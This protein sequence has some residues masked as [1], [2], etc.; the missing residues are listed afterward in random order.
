MTK[1]LGLDLG[2]NSI[3]WAIRNT[4]LTDEVK[5]Q[6]EKFGVL[7][8]KK[9]V[10]SEKGIEYSFA[11]N[12][13]EKRL[14]RRLYQ[15]HKYR[16]WA[17]L[18][19][20]IQNDYCPLS[21]EG[22]NR[23]RKYDK[24]KAMKGEGGRAYPVDEKSFEAWIKLD[25]DGDGH[26][27]YSSPYQL[28][29][30]LAEKKMDLTIQT[31][32]FK[33]GRALY[34]IA[35]RRGF[36]SSR[37]DAIADETGEKQDAKSEIKKES[38][39]ETNL[40][41]KFGKSLSDFPTM[42]SALAFAE[43]QG[44]RVR[45]EWIQH[46]FRKHYKEECTK[47]FEFQ[48]LGTETE[49]YKKLIENSK[50]RYNG[51]IFYQRPL[52]S[53]KGLVGTCT[54]EKGKPRCPLS[55]PEFEEFRAL[56]LLNNIQYK[57]DGSWNNL[58]VDMR[59]QIYQKL[60]LRSSKPHFHF[61]EIR[62]FIEK[63]IG[64]KLNHRDDKAKGLEKSINYSDKTN[65]SACPTSARLKDIFGE[66]WKDYK[67]DTTI[68]RRNKKGIEHTISYTI[69]DIWHVLFSFNDEE[70]VVEFASEKLGLDENRTRK[71]LNA[72]KALQDGYGMLSLYAIKKINEFLREGF[73]YTEA[74][75]L[76]NIP[77]IIG[78]D[79]WSES[80]N[81]K[82]IK[83]SIAD[84]IEKN[85]QIKLIL[86]IVNNLTAKYK[87]LHNDEKYGFRDN[88]YIL[89]ETDKKDILSL[90]IETY[91]EKTWELKIEN[92]AEIINTITDLYQF[93]F[94]NG[95]ETKLFG[96]D[97][98]HVIDYKGQIYHKAVSHQFY[99]LPRIVDTIFD[100]I[101]GHFTHVTEEQL[102]KLYHPSMIE[103][104]PA[105]QRCDDG[106][107]YLQSPK[108]RAFKNPMA[109]RTLHELRKLINYLIKTNKIDEET[110][111]VVETARDL[112]DA[113]KRWAIETFQRQKQAE[114]NEYVEAIRSLLENNDSTSA[115]DPGNLGNVDKVRLWY[116]QSIDESINKG[117]GEYNQ[118]RWNNNSTALF[119]KLSQA[120]TMTE[121][122]RLWK[123]QNC[124]CLYTGRI[125]SITDLFDTNKIDFEHTIPRSISFDNSLANL[126]VC[127]AS[128]NRAVKKNQI[129]TQ[130][131]NF[132]NNS[133]IGGVTY[134]AIKPRL[135][136]WENKVAHIKSMIE[137]W[138]GK[139][140]TASTKDYKDDAIRQRHL[141]Q[142]ELDYW[143]N[144]LER[145]TMTEV[146]TGFKNSQLVDTQLISKYAMHY[147]RSAFNTV[148]VQKGVITAEFRKILGIQA[149]Y[150]QKSRAK[151]SHHA[152]DATVL[153]LIPHAAKREKILQLSFQAE[154]EKKLEHW[155]NFNQLKV[156]VDKEL[157][158]LELPE[159]NRLIDD[160][161]NVVLI[162][163]INRNQV[164]TPGKKVVRSR[165]KKVFLRDV[166]GNKLIDQNETP[167]YK[168][169]KGDCIRGQLH[170][171]TFYGKIKLVER[172]ENN[173]PLRK[174]NN[175]WKF[176]EKN[177]GFAY[178]LRKPVSAISKLDQIVDAHLRNVIEN[179]LKGRSLEKAFLEGIYMLD[180]NG[181]PVGNPMRH[182]RCWAD[183]SNPIPVKQQT[184]ISDK[185]YKN[186]YYA[187]NAENT[188][189]GYYWE[190]K[191]KERGF[192]LLNLF[193]VSSLLK[194]NQSKKLEDYLPKFKELGRGKE[195]KETPLYAALQPGIK[196]LFYKEHP[197]ELKEMV[198]TDLLKRL[199]RINKLFDALSGRIMFDYHLEARTDEELT[200]AFPK[201]TFGQRGK[202]GFSEFN[203]EFPWP[204]LL[205]SPSS[206]NFIVEGRDFNVTPDGLLKLK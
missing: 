92:K 87:S 93:T 7:T 125:I 202:N 117:K 91:G 172:D 127:Y 190:G 36:K 84:L 166:N 11:S 48:S 115:L 3:G 111:I 76:A 147:L 72:W 175:D 146:K 8:F 42:G 179:Q 20:L 155:D 31:N 28:R 10:G 2:T 180:K 173:K 122:Y 167:K 33:F 4:Y 14:K 39:F 68:A 59:D 145:F 198:I 123:E 101:L 120:K 50:N 40:Q 65:V 138:K 109:M 9:G 156:S 83:N 61:L 60:F 23:W 45:Q 161:D 171:D 186:F 169:A 95:F 204:R 77:T 47:I 58:S 141:W 62:E 150:E 56:S 63:S 86:G 15:S 79:V 85:R 55:H 103:L 44:D 24:G 151:H 54:L 110:R 181:N 143:Q 105:A 113:N 197:E 100:F 164:L 149:T 118:N 129:P 152:I 90:I 89:T 139:S 82:L 201:E 205:L 69:E 71:F 174:E 106:K 88:K 94:R 157:Q 132:D 142:M 43:K 126:T 74:V 80:I 34:H 193:Q 188:L 46:T 121:K 206:F 32:R 170:L 199:Y 137:F 116:E 49:L 159:V 99:K 27:D 124:V 102:M 6:I 22:L 13:T 135:K 53:Q 192:E 98:Y 70:L 195:K 96:E 160:I 128:Y 37:K 73:I 78:H 130:L 107:I 165:G 191:S 177:D 104:Y 176:V 16:L 189:Y 183:T 66:Q 158:R 140:K 144:K 81:Q 30:E 178:V 18:E 136:D 35:Q 134:S 52:R 168:I 154:E 182:I 162:D 148:D 25:F 64:R 1:I 131:P 12:R 153:T 57:V 194:T 112:N 38:E 187:A 200:K 17:T 5:N 114:N 163:N 184:Y 75:L 119:Q 203:Y 108:I 97:R 133:S 19:E 29:A 21:I 51:C 67:K 26:P 196:V 185:E 41:Q